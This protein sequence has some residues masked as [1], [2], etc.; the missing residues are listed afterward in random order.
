MPDTALTTPVETPRSITPSVPPPESFAL[1]AGSATLSAGTALAGWALTGLT[2]K[3]LGENGDARPESAPPT[4]SRF[5]KTKT[6][7][8]PVELRGLGTAG[9]VD[10]WKD[11][12]FDDS[13][14]VGRTRQWSAPAVSGRAV[15]MKLGGGGKKGSV[16][17]KVVEEERKKSLEEGGA[18]WGDDW[19]VDEKEDGWG[20]DD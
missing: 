19:D 4:Q 5:A 11:E 9:D 12:E 20:F 10:A 6:A 3:V 15:G 2:K 18:A 1:Q 7:D 16:V 17:E 13:P 14:G 8:T